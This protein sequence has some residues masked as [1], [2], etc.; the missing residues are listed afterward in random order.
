MFDSRYQVIGKLG[1]GAFST[2]WLARD[3]KFVMT[4][5]LIVN[6]FNDVPPSQHCHVA[7][8]VFIRSQAMRSL[9]GR[10]LDTYKHIADVSSTSSHPGRESVRTLLDSFKVEGP[11]GEHQCLVHP[12]LWESVKGLLGCNP[13]GRLPP[14]VVAIVLQRLFQALDFLHNEC[15][16]IHTGEHCGTCR[17]KIRRLCR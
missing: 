14:S 15:H 17:V 16:L 1:Y 6:P 3:L 2:V 12:P 8:K 10:E 7:L 9:V 4:V 11:D 13:D 5:W